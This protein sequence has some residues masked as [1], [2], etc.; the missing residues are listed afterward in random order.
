MWR[1]PCVPCTVYDLL[2]PFKPLFHCA[3]A[4]HFV[5]F[6]WLLVASIRDSGAGTLNEGCAPICLRICRIGH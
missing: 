5:I 3:Q 4:R 1:C 2:Y 6:C